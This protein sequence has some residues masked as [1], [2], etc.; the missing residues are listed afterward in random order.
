VMEKDLER[1]LEKLFGRE[2]A[3]HLAVAKA[4]RPP[5]VPPDIG[6]KRGGAEPTSTTLSPELARRAWRHLQ[7]AKAGYRADD[8]A[9]FGQQMKELEAVLKALKEKADAQAPEP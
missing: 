4:S 3:P 8:W 2:S 6:S 9:E 7:E 5:S 1:S